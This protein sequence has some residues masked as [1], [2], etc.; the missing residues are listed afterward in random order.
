MSVRPPGEDGESGTAAPG[1][2]PSLPRRGMALESGDRSAVGSPLRWLLLLGQLILLVAVASNLLGLWSLPFQK[3]AR[4]ARKAASE[5]APVPAEPRRQ[6]PGDERDTDAIL[7]QF[8]WRE[9]PRRGDTSRPDAG[10]DR[11]TSPERAPE[12]P[13]QR[14]PAFDARQAVAMIATARVQDG[15]ARFRVCAACH[16][17][18]KGGPHKVGPNLWGVVGRAKASREGYSYSAALKAKG[19][20]WTEQELAEFL[21]DPRAYVPGAKMAFRG[22]ETMADVASLIAYLRTQSD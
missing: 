20:I 14:A 15:M 17:E 18:A 1:G 10:R 16:S 12:R 3:A 5:R 7:R 2:Q 19:G 6:A 4:E 9:A 8:G 13:E 21:H 22:I 11:A